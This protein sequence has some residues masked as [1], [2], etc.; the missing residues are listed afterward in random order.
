LDWLLRLE[1]L[2]GRNAYPDLLKASANPEVYKERTVQFELLKHFGYFTTESKEHCSE[3]LPYFNPRKEDREAMGLRESHPK[4]DVDHRAKRWADDSD[5]VR[6]TKG[7][8]PLRTERTFE[9]GM[10]IMHALATDNVYRMN[11]NVLNFGLIDNLP[12]GYC[13]EV[14]CIA[15]RTGV[16]PL[17]VGK[18]PVHLAALCRG[19]ADMQTMASDAVLEKDLNKAY[20]ACAI[21]PCTAA[22]ATPGRIRECF[23]KMLEKETPWLE[24]YWGNVTP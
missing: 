13:V 22:S 24:E 8:I 7:E 2:D 10:H 6:Q 5:L 12:E 17:H 11:V 16:H 18:L 14:P 15:D 23:S 20:L 4:A 3:Y 21:D 19:L 1:Y 9:Y